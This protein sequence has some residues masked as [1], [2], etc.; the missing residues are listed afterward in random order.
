MLRYA[1]VVIFTLASSV[2]ALAPQKAWKPRATVATTR[3]GFL[4]VPVA[5]ALALVAIPN[6]AEAATLPPNL[7]MVGTY[8]D[9]SH[10]EV[11][12]SFRVILILITESTHL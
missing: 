2:G 1:C 4:Q 11:W 3:A 12:N 6:N 7:K 9:P 5:A 8:S 10:P